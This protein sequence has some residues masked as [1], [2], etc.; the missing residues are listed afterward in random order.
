[1][2]VFDASALLAVLF[3]EPG[4]DRVLDWLGEGQ[5]FVSSVNYSEVLAKLLERGATPKQ[6]D[7][8]WRIFD[9]VE[10]VALTGPQARDAAGLRPATKPLGLSLGDRVCLALAREL[11]FPA[12]TAERTWARIGGVEVALIR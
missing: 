7:A 1:M 12:V 4:A 10:I 9:T 2:R 8:S 3:E 11:G 6:A 5:S